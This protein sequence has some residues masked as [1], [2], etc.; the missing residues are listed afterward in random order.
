MSTWA[1][2]FLLDSEALS[3]LARQTLEMQEW[4]TYARRRNFAIF[5]SA[6]TLAE[7]LDGSA[8]DVA[9]YRVLKPLTILPVTAEIGGAAGKLRKVASSL[10]SKPR[11]LT[12]DAIV[13]ATAFT[14]SRPVVILTSDSSDFHLMLGDSKDVSVTRIG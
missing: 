13:A 8:R 7:V 12:V 2:S 11:D 4:V 5:V 10:R 6:A 14:L 1:G 9:V 3:A